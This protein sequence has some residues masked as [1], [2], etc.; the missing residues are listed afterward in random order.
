L[1]Q[2]AS[3]RKLSS[4]TALECHRLEIRESQIG[5]G[6]K[7]FLHFWS[8]TP[9]QKMKDEKKINVFPYSDA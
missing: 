6:T 5:E 2:E 8:Q 7:L 3:K 9:G 1:G 4:D